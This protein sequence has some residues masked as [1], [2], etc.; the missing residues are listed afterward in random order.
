[1]P[2]QLVI[3]TAGAAAIAAA[4][5]SGPYVRIESFKIGSDTS[6][7][8]TSGQTDIIGTLLYSGTPSSYA[9]YNAT[10]VQINIEIPADVGPFDFGE[11][12]LFLPGNVMFGRFSFGA[13]Q[14]KVVDLNNAF[15]DVY[16]LKVLVSDAKGPRI[17]DVNTPE[18]NQYVLE[19]RTL[20]LVGTPSQH[21]GNVIVAAH[22]PSDYDESIHLMRHTSVRW[23]PLNCTKIFSATITGA[24][25][26]THLTAVNFG[27]LYCPAGTVGKY[28]IQTTV[29]EFRS[30][31]TRSGNTIELSSDVATGS[32]V[33]TLVTVYQ[34]NTS[35]FSLLADRVSQLDNLLTEVEVTPPHLTGNG[36][37]ASPLNINWATFIPYLFQNVPCADFYATTDRCPISSLPF[38]FNPA[39]V[40]KFYPPGVPVSSDTL[41]TYSPTADVTLS[42]QSGTVPTGMTISDDGVSLIQISGTPTVEAVHNITYDVSAAGGLGG[43]LTMKIFIQASAANLVNH[44]YSNVGVGVDT[45]ISLE[46]NSSGQSKI[47]RSPG[48]PSSNIAGEWLVYGTNSDMEVRVTETVGTLTSGTVG[49]WLNLGTTRTW[50]KVATTYGPQTVTFTVEIRD[51]STLVVLDS[52]SMTLTAEKVPSGGS[53]VITPNPTTFPGTLMLGHA[54]PPTYGSP[55]TYTVATYSPSGDATLALTSGSLPPGT[56]LNDNGSSAITFTGTPTA[57]GSYSA[58]YS[59]TTTSGY[60]SSYTFNATVLDNTDV[61]ITPHTVTSSNTGGNAT[62]T[63]TLSSDGIARKTTVPGA[64]VTFPG[65]WLLEGTASQYQARATLVSGT[66]T[67]GTLN[68]W[69]ALSTSRSWSKSTTAVGTVNTVINVQIRSIAT[70][71]VLDSAD[72]TLTATRNPGGVITFTPNPA[73]KVFTVGVAVSSS[74]ATYSPAGNATLNLISG[75]LPPGLSLDDVSSTTLKLTGTPTATGAYSAVYS[76]TLP[77]SYSGTFTL[78]VTIAP[79]TSASISNHTILATWFYPPNGSATAS[80]IL[81]SS[82]VA[83]HREIQ[84]GGTTTTN[85][86]G[87]WLVTGDPGNFEVKATIVS[88]TLTNGTTGTWMALDSTRSWS[89]TKSANYGTDTCVLTIQIR[90]IVSQVILDTATITLSAAREM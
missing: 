27:R 19:V 68:T 63:F 48:T 5:T 13:A 69:Q 6:T 85:Y 51:V 24:P 3:T 39:T 14:K 16:R 4:S 37:P 23:N 83:Q 52:A 44:S 22:E 90:N 76:I 40:R 71:V 64:T 56:T 72:I 78:N 80:Y 86:P 81:N 11:I 55:A 21:P 29:G 26:S 36:T 31:V 7:A 50:S 79:E 74:V 73:S 20:D 47:L 32:I 46:L 1:M 41:T 25:D 84:T 15:A 49:T 10:T 82:G 45:T 66:L 57:F 35:I 65:E 12:G 58:T 59:V 9:H 2:T 54:V 89:K 8:S 38:T 70:N 28:Q 17:F 53:L 75:A 43:T 88:G 42:L 77:G 30:V 62:S 87:E 67:S 61:E 18:D 33:G 34:L 60:Y